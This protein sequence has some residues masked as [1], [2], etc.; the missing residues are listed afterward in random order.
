MWARIYNFLQNNVHFSVNEKVKKNEM[1]KYGSQS[2]YS[3]PIGGPIF[4][5]F[6]VRL[7]QYFILLYDYLR[8]KHNLLHP[9]YENV[10]KKSFD[11]FC[12]FNYY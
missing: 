2:G 4:F 1:S 11:R 6:F 5:F 3:C 10:L 12:T 7:N 8:S 9:G